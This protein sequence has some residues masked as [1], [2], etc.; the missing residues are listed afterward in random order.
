MINI[1]NK[2]TGELKM[3]HFLRGRKGRSGDGGRSASQVTQVGD[4][5]TITGS[6]NGLNNILNLTSK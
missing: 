3:L 4:E 5:L 2:G 1:G 6:S